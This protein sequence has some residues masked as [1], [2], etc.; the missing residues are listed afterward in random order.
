MSLDGSMLAYSVDVAGD[1]RYTIAVKDLRTGALLDESVENTYPSVDVVR[2]RPVPL[3]LH[4]DDTWRP[5]KVRRHELGTPTSADVLVC[6]EPDG[7]FWVGR[8]P[9]DVRS[10]SAPRDPLEDHVRGACSRR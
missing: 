7:R 1:E 3:L 2:R 9:H 4:L 6:H 8:E 5:D 10:L